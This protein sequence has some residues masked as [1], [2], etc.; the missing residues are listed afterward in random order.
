MILFEPKYN[1][2]NFSNF[3]F[4][5]ISIFDILLLDKYN[6]FSSLKSKNFK[7]A[8][9]SISFDDKFNFS[10]LSNFNIFDIYIFDTLFFSKFNSFNSLKLKF[11]K[12]SL[13]DILL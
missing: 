7:K 6:S 5:K 11:S 8:I 1:T 9:F 3:I 13:F 10:N 12:K 2:S 4:S